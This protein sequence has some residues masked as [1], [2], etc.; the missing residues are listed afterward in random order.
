MTDLQLPPNKT[1]A[2]KS[3]GLTSEELLT[4]SRQGTLFADAAGRHRLRFRIDGRRRTKY[5]GTELPFIEQIRRELAY[6][7]ADVRRE[8]RLSPQVRHARQ[9]LRRIKS[10]VAPPA[11]PLGFHIR[12][13][14][15]CRNRSA[16]IEKL[17][18]DR[19]SQE[20]SRRVVMDDRQTNRIEGM[21]PQPYA[22][23]E[24]SKNDGRGERFDGLYREAL[25]LQS[26][27]RRVT[28][29][30]LAELL[31]VGSGLADSIKAGFQGST[32]APRD[33]GKN[34]LRALGTLGSIHRA[35][36]RYAVLDA[37][38]AESSDDSES[39]V[40]PGTAPGATKR[41]KT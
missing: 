24:K 4:L 15:L 35:A 3:L 20:C 38:L 21:K 7:Q 10:R 1:I 5:V 18:P 22:A 16:C 23:V 32:K 27:L 36:S 33:L 13:S 25:A 14:E 30:A 2:L 6:L 19:Y 39:T 29:I 8:R 11:I 12:G 17:C 31:E 28:R 41:E 34:M 26:P 9:C 37:K 40:E